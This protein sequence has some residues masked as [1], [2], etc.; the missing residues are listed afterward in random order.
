MSKSNSIVTESISSSEDDRQGIQVAVV[1]EETEHDRPPRPRQ[2]MPHYLRQRTVNDRAL[3]KFES[4]GVG[5]GRNSNAK[6]SK[7]D[8][9]PVHQTSDHNSSNLLSIGQQWSKAKR[10]HKLAQYPNKFLAYGEQNSLLRKQSI[11]SNVGTSRY[12]E[13]SEEEILPIS[14]RDASGHQQRE[15]NKKSSGLSN[16]KMPLSFKP[17]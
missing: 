2:P 9:K 16:F 3:S 8:S 1:Q 14:F 6:A 17:I 5:G 15:S 12:D 11:R 13:V 10:S 7:R 4:G